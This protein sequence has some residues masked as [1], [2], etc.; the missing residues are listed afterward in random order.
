MV[1]R[2]TDVA[3][4]LRAAGLPDD[5]AIVTRLVA[6]AERLRTVGI[7]EG[8]IGPNEAER[9][10]ERHIYESAAIL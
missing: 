5:P 4:N 2:E 8:F 7:A 1:T 3:T 6:L 9:I 10:W